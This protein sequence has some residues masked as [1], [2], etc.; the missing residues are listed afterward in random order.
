MTGILIYLRL[1]ENL[2]NAAGRKASTFA[3]RS[4][5][6]HRPKFAKELALPTRKEKQ[7]IHRFAKIKSADTQCYT[8]KQI[9][10]QIDIEE[11]K[12]PQLTTRYIQNGRDCAKIMD[13]SPL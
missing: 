4:L 2:I 1:P 10:K 8:I 3:N 9:D 6:K 11:K 5:P 13:C 7:K 12:E